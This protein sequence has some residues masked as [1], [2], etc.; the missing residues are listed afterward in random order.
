MEYFFDLAV[1]GTGAMS[2]G[3][4]TIFQATPYLNI[5]FINFWPRIKIDVP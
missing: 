5:L 1:V 2:N 3:I 4:E